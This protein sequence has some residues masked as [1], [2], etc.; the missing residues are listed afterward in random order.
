MSSHSP[1]RR[2]A[3]IICDTAR[4]YLYDEHP[5][6]SG[7]AQLGW[8]P[9]SRPFAQPLQGAERPVHDI[10]FSR[11]SPLAPLRS[12]SINPTIKGASWDHTAVKADAEQAHL[13]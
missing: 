6:R 3:G 10:A 7:P 8:R 1:A 12:V 11:R 5:A 13:D 4:N 2:V 9:V